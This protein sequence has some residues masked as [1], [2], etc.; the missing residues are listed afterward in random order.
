MPASIPLN[1]GQP[2][3]SSPSGAQSSEPGAAVIEVSDAGVTP[4]EPVAG[5]G[6]ALGGAWLLLAGLAAL[7]RRRR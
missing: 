6:G 4:T 5:K 2:S 1:L 7:L 3:G